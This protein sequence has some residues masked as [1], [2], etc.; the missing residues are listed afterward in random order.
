MQRLVVMLFPVMASVLPAAERDPWSYVRLGPWLVVPEGNLTAGTWQW[1]PKAVA[2]AQASREAG[3]SD[4]NGMAVLA[5]AEVRWQPTEVDR[6]QFEALGGFDVTAGDLAQPRGHGGLTWERGGHTW[7][8]RVGL[9]A[10]RDAKTQEVAPAAP[11]R[12]AGSAR[13]SAG[14]TGARTRVVALGRWSAER[15]H[16]D[17][18]WLEAA[19]AGFQEGGGSLTLDRSLGARSE[20]GVTSEVLH[21]RPE[22]A[23]PLPITTR[24]LVATTLTWRPGDRSAVRV[25][26]GARHWS[27][28]APH[29]ADPEDRTDFLRPEAEVGLTWNYRDPDEGYVRL[30][31]FADSLPAQGAVVADR[32]AVEIR[33]WHALPRRFGVLVEGNVARLEDQTDGVGRPREVFHRTVGQVAVFY[34]PSYGWRAWVG[35]WHADERARVAPATASTVWSV[36]TAVVF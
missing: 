9:E 10:D 18:F 28:A 32:R 21:R 31:L 5:G 24:S 15:V 8:F 20:V 3:G 7:T 36:N 22:S 26:A 4:S 17:T 14:W 16:E 29:L 2:S 13:A 25:L 23:G 27:A 33:W 6:A 1:H 12:S 35:L 34:L 19:S 11:E 30:R